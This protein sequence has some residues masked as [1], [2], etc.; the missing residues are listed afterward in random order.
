[1]SKALNQRFQPEIGA[2]IKYGITS[3][4]TADLALNPDFS[5][6]ESDIPQNEVNQRYPLY[7]PEKRPFFLEGKDIF[8]TP[9]ELLYSRKIISPV[10]AAKVTGKLGNTSFGVMSA[11]DDRPTGIEIPGAAELEEDAAYRSL[12]SVLRL[13]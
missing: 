11:L 7:Y 13:R 12:N 6:I 8:D 3:D 5:Q 1:M 4:V 9:F 2:N 10:W